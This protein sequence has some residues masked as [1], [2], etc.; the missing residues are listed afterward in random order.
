MTLLQV[1]CTSSAVPNE[2]VNCLDNKSTL[3]DSDKLQ[4]TSSTVSWLQMAW[5]MEMSNKLIFLHCLSCSGSA[6][7]MFCLSY[8]GDDD[9]GGV[10]AVH[11]WGDGLACNTGVAVQTA[12]MLQVCPFVTENLQSMHPVSLHDV[13]Q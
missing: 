2:A 3:T 8:R 1:I 5:I 13:M 10:A 11:G 6:A 7:C 12:V 4:G 9:G